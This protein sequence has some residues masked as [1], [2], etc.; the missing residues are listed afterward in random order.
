MTFDNVEAIKS[1]VAVGL[2]ASIVPSLCLGAGHVPTSDIAVVPLSPRAGRRIGL[3][4]LRGKTATE[5]MQIVS[6][7]LLTL[8]KARQRQRTGS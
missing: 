8:R 3:V 4:Q 6:T 7:A 2:G 5:A 1:L